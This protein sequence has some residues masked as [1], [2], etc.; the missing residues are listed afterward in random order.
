MSSFLELLQIYNWSLPSSILMSMTLSLIGA[1][2]I[3]RERSSQ[4]FVLGQGTSLGIVLG[5]VLNI[6]FQTDLHFLNLILGFILGGVTLL[7]S[8]RLI[9]RKADR[10]HIYLTLFIFFLALTYLLTAL[11]PSLETHMASAYFGDLA[12][13]SNDGAKMSLVGALMFTVLMLSRW[14]KL[15]LTSFQVM[16]QSLVHRSSFNRVFDIGTLVITTLAIQN[17]GYLF[18]IGCLFIPTSFAASKS[19]NLKDYTIRIL[20]ISSLGTMA[21]FTLSLFSTELPTVPCILLG[22]IFIGI[23]NLGI[24]SK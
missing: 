19:R 4:I 10:N 17:M 2:W 15:T 3:S 12:V 22:Q 5:L 13:M 8:D 16:N 7:L 1:Q 23:L 24:R 21:G 20:L 11:T 18:S 6:L 9:Q 14:R